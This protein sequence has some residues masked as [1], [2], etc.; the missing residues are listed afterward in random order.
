MKKH[1][2]FFLSPVVVDVVKH[3]KERAGRKKK[4]K[5]KNAER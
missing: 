1:F 5:K 4:K 3:L 2:A